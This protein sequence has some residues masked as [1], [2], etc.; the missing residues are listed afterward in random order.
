MKIERLIRDFR[1]KYL[2]IYKNEKLPK[3]IF[4]SNIEKRKI[5]FCTTCMNRLFHLR[6]TFEKNI[7]NNL[8]YGNVEFV[9]INYNSEDQLNDWVN[10]N[11]YKYIQNGILH[12]YETKEPKRFHASKAKNLAHKLA[13]GNIFCNLDGDN[14]T[15]LHF[16]YYINYIFNCLGDNILLHFRK[17]P[18]WGTEGRICLTRENFF[19]LGG[20]D[21]SLKPIGH[22]DHDLIERAKAIGLKY[23]L[24]QIEN[25]LRYLSNTTE[26][27][28][29]NCTFTGENYYSM[30]MA[31]REIS[32][33]N[34]KDEVFIANPEGWGKAVVYKNF[35][36]EAIII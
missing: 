22:E 11:L 24:V 33:Q 1:D 4:D 15:G 21:E 7:L 29:V 30:E 35:S 18:F 8:S 26:E 10:Q 6:Q 23:E 19:R 2:R 17:A 5:S 31:N 9:L 32:K 27:K 20:Y 13:S 25:F 3:E 28:A 34:I 14:F 12:Y 36:K 16:A